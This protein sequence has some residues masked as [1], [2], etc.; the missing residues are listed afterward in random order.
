MHSNARPPEV[1]TRGPA[2][3]R[4]WRPSD[5]EALFTAVIVS[6]DHLRP[7]MPW[8]PGYSR[9]SA[10]EF[11]VACDLDWDSGAAFNYAIT[12]DGAIAGSCG[13]MA[14]LGPGALEIGYWVHRDYVR[15]GLATAATEVLTEAAFTLPGIDWVEVVH[16]ELNVFSEAIPR[17]LG[18]IRAGQRTLDMP[19][20]GGTGVGIVWRRDRPAEAQAAAGS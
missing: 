17:K 6:Q 18:F 9:Q 12:V 10:F 14:R 5:Q 15:R 8:A 19:P 16:D 20:E 11:I 3:L 2:T 7:W 4:R 13:L 1:L